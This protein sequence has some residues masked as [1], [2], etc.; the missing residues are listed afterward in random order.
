VAVL[1]RLAAQR[2]DKSQNS[3]LRDLILRMHGEF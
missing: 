1:V 2:I 3:G